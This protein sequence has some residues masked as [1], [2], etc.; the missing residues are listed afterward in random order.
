M[1]EPIDVERVMR[2]IAA[3]KGGVIE[4]AGKEKGERFI[5]RN[6]EV[7]LK[8]LFEGWTEAETLS[9]CEWITE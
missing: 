9:K 7:L 1:S 4:A 8:G 6:I 5:G 3:M 2:N